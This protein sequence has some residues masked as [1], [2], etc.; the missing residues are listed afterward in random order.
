MDK[1][2]QEELDEYY[3]TDDV[4][5]LADLVEVVYAILKYK[6]VDIEEFENIRRKKILERG[7]FDKRIL[8]REVIDG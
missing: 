3:S 5:E 8:L 6:K 1:K 4:E 7:T 2:L